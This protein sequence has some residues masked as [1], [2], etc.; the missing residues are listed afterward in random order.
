MSKN[1]KDLLY[2]PIVHIIGRKNAIGE[3][4]KSQNKRFTIFLL[5]QL[6]ISFNDIGCLITSRISENVNLGNILW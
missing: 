1:Y 6:I 2:F 4:P 5:L 3:I